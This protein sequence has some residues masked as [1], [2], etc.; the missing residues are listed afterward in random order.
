M[1]TRTLLPAEVGIDDVD[2]TVTT[3]NTSNILDVRNGFA[4]TSIVDITETGTPTAGAADLIVDVMSDGT[5]SA[6]V[7]YTVSLLT[8]IDIQTSGDRNTVTFGA[9]VTAQKVGSGSLSADADVIKVIQFLRLN[10]KASTAHESTTCTGD[11][12]LLIEEV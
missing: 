8:G 11:V 9:G 3:A 12:T 1:A 6:T 4:F 10:L 5:A 2:L 7:L